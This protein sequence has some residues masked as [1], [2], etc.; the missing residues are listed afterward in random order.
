M[1]RRKFLKL[2]A[3]SSS[4]IALP[5]IAKVKEKNIVKLLNIEIDKGNNVEGT[6]LRTG[7]SEGGYWVPEDIALKLEANAKRNKETKHSIGDK[8]RNAITGKEYICLNT[9]PIVWIETP[10]S[11]KGNKS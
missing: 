3:G 4:L 10:Q 6:P 2:L 1:K 5:A 7:M 11:S 9:D 8:W